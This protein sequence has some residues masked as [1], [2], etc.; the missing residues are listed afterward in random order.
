MIQVGRPDITDH[1]PETE[2][3]VQL[4]GA[5]CLRLFSI[6]RPAGI[7]S[8]DL[9]GWVRLFLEEKSPLPLDSLHWAYYELPHSDKLV[10]YCGWQQRIEQQTGPELRRARL[11]LPEFFIPRPQT[12]SSAAE[13]RRVRIGERILELTFEEGDQLPA[14]YSCIGTPDNADDAGYTVKISLERRALRVEWL[15]TG[16]TASETCILRNWK[17]LRRADPRKNPEMIAIEQADQSNQRFLQWLAAAAAAIVL[18]AAIQAGSILWQVYLN[19]LA[20]SVTAEQPHTDQLQARFRLMERLQQM[21]TTAWSPFDLLSVVNSIRPPGIHFLSSQLVAKD[22]VEIRGIANTVET[23]NRFENL[24]LQSP[25]IESVE[26]ISL[27]SRGEVTFTI[28][29][30]FHWPLPAVTETSNVAVV[31]A[32]N[33][34]QPL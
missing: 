32:G 12:G 31:P 8:R 16:N 33:A 22:Y 15:S 21:G 11:A 3:S 27:Q 5:D 24:L 25:A 10:I 23:V 4:I 7:R 2:P 29:V 9:D 1:P 18:L 6:P 14:A 19:R 30:H 13:T 17:Q 28:A 20:A 26:R 34:E